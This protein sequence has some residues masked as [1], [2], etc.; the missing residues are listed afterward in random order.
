MR[1]FPLKTPN[2]D[3]KAMNTENEVAALAR[4][5]FQHARAGE[6]SRLAWLVSSGLP[7]NLCNEKGDTLL[8]LACYYGHKEA[9][10]FLL[11]SQADP[12]RP[13]DRGQTP[14]A[15]AAF[16]GDVLIAELLLDHGARVDGTG[17]DGKTAL[18]FAAMFDRV[19]IIELLLVR[20]AQPERQDAEGRTALDY[21][22][23][24]GARRAADRLAQLI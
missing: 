5:A 13:N 17:P 3:V 8:M 16:M 2:Q 23:A 15:G 7:V 22:H 24:M 20:G 12:D 21:A 10:R 18:M 9:A 11:E 1:T 4:A 6:T 19:A 14:L